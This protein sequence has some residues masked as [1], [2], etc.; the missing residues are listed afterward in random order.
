[1]VPPSSVPVETV[2]A[3]RGCRGIGQFGVRTAGRQQLKIVSFGKHGPRLVH[4][5]PS[6][7]WKLPAADHQLATDAFQAAKASLP[8][9]RRALLDR[10]Q[11]KDIAFKMV[12][13]GS[14]GTFCVVVLLAT[15]DNDPLLLEIKAA[16]KRNRDALP[17]TGTTAAWPSGK[18]AMTAGSMF[19][20]C[21]TMARGVWVSQSVSDT[22][23][24]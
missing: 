3:S 5:D 6:R 19:M 10:Y 4:D 14:V 8:P 20:V 18:R 9:E 15:P 21:A 13:V 1:M 24:K 23:E 2:P 12:S 7:M 17:H 22:S 16:G 11:L